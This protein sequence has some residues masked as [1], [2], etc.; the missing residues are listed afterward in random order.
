MFFRVV[1]GQPEVMPHSA[2]VIGMDTG[3]CFEVV[4]CSSD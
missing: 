2:A 4:G 1:A 3:V